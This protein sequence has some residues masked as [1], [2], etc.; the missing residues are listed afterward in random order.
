M[1]IDMSEYETQKYESL[2]Y[3]LQALHNCFS[4]TVPE[5]LAIAEKFHDAMHKGLT[6]QKG[7]LKMLPSFLGIPQWCRKRSVFICRFRRHKC[8]NFF[9][10]P[11]GER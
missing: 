4:V 9:N 3:A 8:Q 2:N 6:G 7:P 11:A 1:G 5:M 10:Q